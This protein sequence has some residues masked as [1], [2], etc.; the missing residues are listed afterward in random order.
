MIAP[1]VRRTLRHEIRVGVHR[2]QLHLGIHT[3]GGVDPL[4]EETHQI[5]IDGRR[6]IHRNSV[7][8]ESTLWL[9]SDTR[10]FE[11]GDGSPEVEST[12]VCVALALD[13]GVGQRL[14]TVGEGIGGYAH[15]LDEKLF[16]GG[17]ADAHV[18]VG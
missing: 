1:I 9:P 11:V 13:L 7:V 6:D 3:G 2:N 8:A 16:V 10:W 15:E 14:V 18:Q 5:V 4:R 17:G 12:V